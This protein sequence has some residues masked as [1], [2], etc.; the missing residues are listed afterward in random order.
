MLHQGSTD[1]VV[2]GAGV[3]GLVAATRASELGRNVVVLE[4]GSEEDYMCNS[5]LTGG[6]FHIGMDDI[7]KDPADA[8]AVIE[9]ATEGKADPALASALSKNGRRAVDWLRTQ[10]VRFIKG[11]TPG[12][13]VILSP[14]KLAR[15]GLNWKGRAGDVL[16]HTLATRIGEKGGSVLRGIRARRLIMREGRCVGVE[17][18]GRNG[19]MEFQASAVIIADG[20]FQANPDLV[21]RYISPAPEKVHQR[22]AKSGLGDGLI[23]AEQVGAKLVGLDRFYG[24]IL[25]RS[26]RQNDNLW[27]YPMMDV[28]ATAGVAVDNN[29]L[30]FDDEGI[31]GI[32]LSNKIAQLNDPLS[33]TLIFDEAIWNGPAKDWVLPPNPNLEMAKGEIFKVGSLQELAVAIG[34]P[35]DNLMATISAYN[36][37]ID[38]GRTAQMVPP[39]STDK[40]RPMPIRTAPFRAVPVCAGITYTMGGIAIDG[41]ARVLS[42]DGSVIEGL[43][44]AGSAT[45]GLEGGEHAGY[46]GGLSKAAVFGLL[47]AEQIAGA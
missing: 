41:Q 33:V 28:I 3:A 8:H 16:L 10:G 2:I 21:R 42:N 45:G 17:A 19:S 14:P 6:V 32:Y 47:A 35:A 23:M 18:D 12:M 22:N 26:A 24:H 13:S 46:T 27:P 37:A 20:G 5:R 31:G 39:R 44:A 15:L 25:H 36:A 1:V 11:P 30:R 29:G 4:R 7:L 38:E 40:Y 9:A 43:F 34:V